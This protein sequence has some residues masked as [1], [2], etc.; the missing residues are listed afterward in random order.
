MRNAQNH[1]DTQEIRVVLAVLTNGGG[2]TEVN[3]YD[4]IGELQGYY[5]EYKKIRP[6]DLSERDK[7]DPEDFRKAQVL[8]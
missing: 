7:I 2:L 6:F 5:G 3:V 4:G 8:I 1:D